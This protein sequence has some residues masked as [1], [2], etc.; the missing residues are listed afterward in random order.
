[1]KRQAH[2]VYVGYGKLQNRFVFFD[3]T[4]YTPHTN[5]VNSRWSQ[6]SRV[7]SKA[8]WGFH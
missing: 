2:E 3:P 1:M 8:G 6:K 7:F 4:P 5:F